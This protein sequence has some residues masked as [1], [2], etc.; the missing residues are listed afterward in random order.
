MTPEEHESIAEETT[1][2][3]YLRLSCLGYAIE[4]L[5]VRDKGNWDVLET[6]EKYYQWVNAKTADNQPLTND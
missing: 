1:D 3:R 5:N 6:A 4:R 2:D